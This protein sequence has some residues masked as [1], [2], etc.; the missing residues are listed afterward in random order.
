MLLSGLPDTRIRSRSSTQ[1]PAPALLLGLPALPTELS[2]GTVQVDQTRPGDQ[3]EFTE[4]TPVG[5]VIPPDQ[6]VPAPPFEGELLDQSAY[7]STSLDGDIAVLNIWGS[8]W[9]PCRIETPEF[10]V[11]HKDVADDGVHFLGVDVKDQRQLAVAF[12]QR[13]GATYPSLFDPRGEVALAFRALRGA[14]LGLAKCVGLCV[15]FVM[16]ALGAQRALR[17]S[18][19][20]RRHAPTVMRVGGAVLIVLGVLLVTGWWDGL[21][22]WLRAWL[23]ATGFGTS[24]L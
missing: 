2:S 14:V 19:A 10:Q 12:V 23:A 6:R 8:W 1:R 17:L 21:M 11:V 3:Y 16:V 7:S 13:V 18:K 22:I 5:T 9:A 20:V 4:A 24:A 15:P